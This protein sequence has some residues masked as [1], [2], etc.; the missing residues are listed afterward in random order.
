[1]IY[2][3]LPKRAPRRYGSHSS[4]HRHCDSRAGKFTSLN[5]K[6]QTKQ[7]SGSANL[8][9][10]TNISSHVVEFRCNL[11]PSHLFH[12]YLHITSL[13]FENFTRV[14]C[15][16]IENVFVG[17][18]APIKGR[19]MRLPPIQGRFGLCIFRLT[20]LELKNMLV[21]RSYGQNEIRYQSIYQ[22]SK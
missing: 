22:N 16:A 13:L 14:R 11:H 4:S 6:F 20:V 5:I 21:V 9:G 18:F 10:W 8:T 7:P 19:N 3:Q 17:R 2:G 1:M 15:D 12:S